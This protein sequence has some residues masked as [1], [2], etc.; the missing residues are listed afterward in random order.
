MATYTTTYAQNRED[1]IIDAFFKGKKSGFY[2]D[3]GA[4]HPV[5]DSVTK[6]FYIKGWRGINIEPNPILANL[7]KADRSQDLTITKGVGDKK[8]NATLRIYTNGD[9]L[10]TYSDDVKA[11]KG[12]I[13][14]GIKKEYDDVETEIDTLEG[15]FN[16]V[17]D[18]K[19]I[20][21]MK[22]DVEGLE[23]AVLS[24]NDWKTYRPELICIE[25]NH[26]KVDWHPLLDKVGYTQFFN[27]GLNDYYA[28]NDS[29][30]VKQFSFPE[31]VFMVYPKI[32]PFIPHKD[33][34]AYSAEPQFAANSASL[35]QDV[36]NSLTQLSHSSRQL[37]TR[38]ITYLKRRRLD[39]AMRAY[40]HTD[41]TNPIGNVSYVTPKIIL[42]KC[43]LV[44][45][46][47][48]FAVGYKLQAS[49]KLFR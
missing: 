31:S 47:A 35:K 27:D 2:V 22:I 1:I 24:G 28:E 46:N 26:V 15:I 8:G 32:V 41:R 17:P 39:E 43:M 3:I 29:Q 11:E 18:L 25:S 20:D 30:L 45:V 44:C 40:V 23:Y 49:R 36:M 12:T 4:N 10:S 33:K 14:D 38:K 34:T 42:L 48:V 5:I 21:F 19:R 9:G 13:Y 6:L 37:L 7:L 16:S